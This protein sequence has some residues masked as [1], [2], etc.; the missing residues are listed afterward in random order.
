[1]T[2]IST[3]MK[4]LWKIIDIIDIRLSTILV[5]VLATIFG[6]VKPMLQMF[7]IALI[8]EVC[9]L[10]VC[11]ILKVKIEKFSILPFGVALHINEVEN[12]SSVKQ[13]LI[14]LAGPLSIF[15]NLPWI[16]LLFN[17][18]YINEINY[19]FLFRINIVMCVVNLIPI[20]P[21][22]GYMIVKALLQLFFPYKN[23]LKI[24]III[25]LLFLV[26]FI[27]Y[28]F[29]SFQPMITSF[30]ILEQIKHIVNYK[31]L[32]RKF[33]VYKS[34]LRK[35]KKYK[36]ID[37]YQMYKDCNNYKIENEKILNDVDIATKELKNMLINE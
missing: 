37:N 27:G 3:L 14:Y 6:F 7:F 29:I 23:S 4:K 11:L 36:V 34:F 15:I 17:N 33:L 31:N 21:L 18:G 35:Q 26:V 13:I 22:D 5:L 8:H 24:S 2:I 32:Y 9:H 20:Y 12:I 25:S 28:N 1:M 19:Q 16:V 10:I 30:L